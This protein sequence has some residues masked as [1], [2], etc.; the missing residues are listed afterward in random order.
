M[1]PCIRSLTNDFSTKNSMFNEIYDQVSSTILSN[2]L[3]DK[4]FIS[5]QGDTLFRRRSF[6]SVEV[7]NSQGK[8]ENLITFPGFLLDMEQTSRGLSFLGCHSSGNYVCNLSEEQATKVT[9][10]YEKETYLLDDPRFVHRLHSF[11][12]QRYILH[13][14]FHYAVHQF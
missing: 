3:N 8:R 1:H 13:G 4:I 5:E 9:D 14:V 12:D 2:H 7:L 6:N 10:I 11:G